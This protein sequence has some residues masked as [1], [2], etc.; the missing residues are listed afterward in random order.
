MAYKP[1]RAVYFI[2]PLII[3]FKPSI[4]AASSSID[5]LAIFL[6]ILFVDIVRTWLILTRDF[7]G[8]FVSESSSVRGNPARWDWIDKDKLSHFYPRHKNKSFF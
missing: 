5:E 6:P 3:S 8:S 2:Q 7:F 1:G 4:M